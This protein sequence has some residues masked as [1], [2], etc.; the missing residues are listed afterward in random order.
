MELLRVTKE[1]A[2]IDL[3]EK[4]AWLRLTRTENVGPVTFYRLLETYG[5][6]S[7]AIDALPELA[8]RGG[9]AKPLRAAP[10]EEIERE[11]QSLQ[12]FGGDILCAGETHYPAALAAI[13]DAPPVLTYA[14]DFNLLKKV[15]IGVVG[16]RNASLN[17]RK[18]TEKMAHELGASGVTIV[19]GLARGIDTAA[20][21]GSLET[22]TVAVLGGGLDIIYPPENKGLYAKIR[23]QGLIIAESPFGQQ[24]FAQSFPRRNRIISGLSRGVVIVEATLRSGSLITARMAGEQGRDVFAVPGHPL[25][26]RAEGPNA[27]IRDGALLT[28][29]AADILESLSAFPEESLQD[30]A[31][32]AYEPRG[33]RLKIDDQT[34]DRTRMEVLSCLSHAPIA[35]DEII[36]SAVLAP[37]AVQIVILEL[38]LAGRAQRL[39]GQRVSLID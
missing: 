17:G 6:A 26:P 18:F 12:E 20:H 9:R 1:I 7:N 24:P 8:R 21:A 30:V 23:E 15:C 11:Y 13:D 19:S 10:V 32:Q 29:N 16:S 31:R 37:A 14:G 2:T 36:R 33:A 22:G 5:S 35:I 34:L 4:M 39:P 28:R 25:D 38:E 27:L 3:K